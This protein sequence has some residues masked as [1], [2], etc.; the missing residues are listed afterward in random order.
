MK[1]MSGKIQQA[2]VT[3]NVDNSMMR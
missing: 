3:F 2:T 1:R